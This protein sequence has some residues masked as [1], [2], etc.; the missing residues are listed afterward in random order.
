[1]VES[2][3]DTLFTIK[4][5]R[6]LAWHIGLT[7][8]LYFPCNQ[9]GRPRPRHFNFKTF[10]ITILDFIETAQEACRESNSHSHRTYD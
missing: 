10:F 5:R 2:K 8:T 4:A 7:R 9:N 6:I 3:E 1:M